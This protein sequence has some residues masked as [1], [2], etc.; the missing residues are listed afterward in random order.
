MSV[1]IS[2]VCVP[3]PLTPPH[4]GE[5]ELPRTKSPSPLR[6]WVKGGGTLLVGA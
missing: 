2:Y 3:P 4:K 5:G 1:F 6:G